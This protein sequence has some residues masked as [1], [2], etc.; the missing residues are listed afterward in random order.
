MEGKPPKIVE[1]ENVN[2]IKDSAVLCKFSRSFVDEERLA[3]LLDADYDELLEIGAEIVA[4]ERH[5]NNQRGFDRSDD[6]PTTTRF[7]ASRRDSRSTTRN[8]AGTT[9]GRFPTE[10][11]TEAA[12]RPTTDRQSTR[13][14]SSIRYVSC[15]IPAKFT[16]PESRAGTAAT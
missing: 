11:S 6:A 16:G 5:F 4:L 13:F 3:T 9:T 14:R 1:L 12:F 8:A 7:P 10:R 15:P 2:A